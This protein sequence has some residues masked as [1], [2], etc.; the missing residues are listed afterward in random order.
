MNLSASH[1]NLRGLVLPLALLVLAELA[2]RTMSGPSDS[3]APPSA[4]VQAGWIALTDGTVLRSTRDTLVAVVSG[5]SIGVL[6]GVPLGIV[7]GISATAN[8]LMEFTIESIRPIPSVALIPVALLTF[9]L[10]YKMEIA[11]VAFSS[12]WPNLILTRAAVIG[13]EP[14]LK[15][16]AR[17]LGFGPIARV[18]KILLPA[19]L[20]RIFVGFRLAAAVA[21]IVAV[22]VEIAANPYGLGY[23]LMDAQQS[24]RPDLMLALLFWVGLIGWLFNKALI[25][26]QYRLFGP[27]AFVEEVR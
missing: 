21:L 27:A 4:I 10:G 9:G 23:A 1:L 3:L 16:V 12:T 20:P 26:A 5:L 14:R 6:I 19:A 7:L 8:R 18:T 11:V 17:V 2:G 22:T 24:L 25:T 15:E 13:V